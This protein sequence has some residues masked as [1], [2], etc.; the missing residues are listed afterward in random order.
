MKRWLISLSVLAAALLLASC[1]SGPAGDP[2]P[3]EP[4]G[5]LRLESLSVELPRSGLSS[6]ALAQAVRELPDAL[7]DAL[8]AQGVE[9]G[10]VTVSVGSSP[11]AMAQAVGEGGVDVAFLAREDHEALEGAPWPLLSAAP[12]SGEAPDAM[13]AIVRADDEALSGETFA[14]ALAAAVNGLREGQPVFGPYDY[15]Y[16]QPDEGISG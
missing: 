10:T 8:E 15:A 2:A 1:G 12:A 9:A 14:A 6:Q 7:K 3:P 11:E 16:V 5:P 13:V 4:E